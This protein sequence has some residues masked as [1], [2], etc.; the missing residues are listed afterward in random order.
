[1]KDRLI[2][3]RLLLRVYVPGEGNI[4]LARGRISSRVPKGL[5]SNFHDGFMVV[6]DEDVDVGDQK[7]REVYIVPSGSYTFLKGKDK[8]ADVFIEPVHVTVS[9]TTPDGEWYSRGEKGT[10]AELS[11]LP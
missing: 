10:F 11:L 1:M 8:M 3:A 7:V 6:L 2:G 5:Q 4:G 9:W